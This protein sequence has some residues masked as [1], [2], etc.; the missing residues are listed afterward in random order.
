MSFFQTDVNVFTF[1]DKKNSCSYKHICICSFTKALYTLNICL[2]DFAMY[3][4]AI[5]LENIEKAY[6]CFPCHKCQMRVFHNY[7]A[8]TAHERH[9]TGMAK[10]KQLIVSP[11]EDNIDP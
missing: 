11:K 9:C 7:N 2:V 1:H 10:S 5:W 3:K 4:H 8:Y 6:N